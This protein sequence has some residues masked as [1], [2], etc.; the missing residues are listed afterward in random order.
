MGNYCSIDFQIMSNKLDKEKEPEKSFTNEISLKE[1]L[2]FKSYK[3]YKT[4]MNIFDKK[5]KVLVHDI[6]KN[7]PSMIYKFSKDKIRLRLGISNV[8]FKSTYTLHKLYSLMQ[9]IY[10]RINSIY[11]NS[12]I[13]PRSEIAKINYNLITRYI[14]YEENYISEEVEN[15]NIANKVIRRLNFFTEEF[16]YKLK[17]LD[18]IIKSKKIFV[19]GYDSYYRLTFYIRPF[20]NSNSNNINNNYSSTDNTT[21]LNSPNIV[22]RFDSLNKCNLDISMCTNV[23]IKNFKNKSSNETID[24]IIYIFF[25]I[26]FVLPSLKSL[27]NFSEEINIFIDYNNEIVDTEIVRLLLYYINNNYP[28]VLNRICVDN[29]KLK[30]KDDLLLIESLINKDDLFNCVV[31]SGDDFKSQ[32]LKYFFS[33]F[34]PEEYGGSYKL[35]LSDYN[36]IK[37][38]DDL[39][40]SLIKSILIS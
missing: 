3:E 25:V 18:K 30:N 2:D 31:F 12:Y 33:E 29:Y 5:V 7:N 27:L 11:N 8:R 21:N 38:I 28:L 20:Y 13:F 6:F 24:Y 40:V 14:S 39:V 22:T 17:R 36:N 23:N 1:I 19:L 16:P 32:I 15:L 4:F 34:I 26:E 35:D 9:T 10:H 37:N